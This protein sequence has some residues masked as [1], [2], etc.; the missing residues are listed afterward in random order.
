LSLLPHDA[1]LSEPSRL[2]S[3][4]RRSEGWLQQQDSNLRPGGYTA[5]LRFRRAWTIS[6]PSASRYGAGRSSWCYSGLHP[7]PVVSAP[8]SRV[9]EAWLRVAVSP[10]REG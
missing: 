3:G 8:S 5:S 6:S 4:S 10:L 9:R 2:V 7:N 1:R